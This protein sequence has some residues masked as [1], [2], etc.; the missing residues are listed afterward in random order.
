MGNYNGN[1]KKA[2]LLQPVV[3]GAFKNG[4]ESKRV[5]R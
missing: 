3:A 4:M 1:E 2:M 5:G